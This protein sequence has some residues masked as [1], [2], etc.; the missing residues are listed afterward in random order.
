MGRE[1]GGGFRMGNTGRPVVDSFP[2]MAEPIQHFKFK[3]K[4]KL[5]KKKKNLTLPEMTFLLFLFVCFISGCSAQGLPFIVVHRLLIA[6][7]SLVAEHRL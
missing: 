1:E 2:Y 6:A 3:N 4:T 7:A 5:K